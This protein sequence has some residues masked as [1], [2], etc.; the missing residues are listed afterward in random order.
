MKHLFSLIFSGQFDELFIL[1]TNNTWIQIFRSLFVGG[2]SF[3]VD[4]A[5]LSILEGLG[6]HYLTAA[7]VAFIFGLV[8]NYI[9]S[10]KFVF[11]KAAA[12][13]KAE[14]PTFAVIG[15]IGLAFTEL[16]MYLFTGV[17][18]F[19]VLVSKAIAAVIVLFWNFSARK[20]ILYRNS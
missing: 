2:L 11:T 19:Y 1:P 7:A 6:M 17:L 13:A 4:S 10:K 5:A 18:G 3:L 8:F 12:N 15:V 20:L 9:L 16:L 14:F